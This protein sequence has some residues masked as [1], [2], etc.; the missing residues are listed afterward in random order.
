VER[1]SH[2][3]ALIAKHTEGLNS[4]ELR[5]KVL[6][7]LDQAEYKM[8]LL[9]PFA[10]EGIK[11]ELGASFYYRI[12]V[13]GSADRPRFVITAQASSARG[14][15]IVAD[16]VQHEYEKLYRSTKS[17]KVEFV[18]QTLENLLENSLAKE[19]AIASEIAAHAEDEKRLS[20]DAQE[21]LKTY[22]RELAVV[23]ASTDA[24]R[25]RLNEVKIQ[26]ALP[27]EQ[28][29]PLRRENLAVLPSSPVSALSQPQL[30]IEDALLS[31]DLA[32]GK[33]PWQRHGS[34]V[35]FHES[36]QKK[37]EGTY[38]EGKEAGLWISY[39]QDGKETDR[40]SFDGGESNAT[41]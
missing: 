2:L 3:A 39:D 35:A 11:T 33:M 29:E 23:R 31:K 34:F 28:D 38:R 27:S 4:Q 24:I 18:K 6:S 25:A 12:E 30:R 21:R 8:V 14:A 9:A 5:A 17:E 15:M 41:Q 26:Q 19:R 22:E 32:T 37:I 20:D 10:M 7:R 40:K 16:L 1:D 13:G 36:G